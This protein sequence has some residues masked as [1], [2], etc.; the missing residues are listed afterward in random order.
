MVNILIVILGI[1]IFISYIQHGRNMYNKGKEDAIKKINELIAEQAKKLTKE[2][3]E[4][5]KQLNQET[6]KMIKEDKS[7]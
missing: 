7:K 4:L 5:F 6:D 1:M 2:A 3:E